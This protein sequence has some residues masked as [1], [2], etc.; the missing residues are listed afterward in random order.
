MP[1]PL[2]SR[3]RHSDGQRVGRA[4]VRLR[5]GDGMIAAARI[6]EQMRA[7]GKDMA[8]G[9]AGTDTEG[10]AEDKVSGRRQPSQQG[11]GNAAG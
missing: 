1:I 10:T 11:R 5:Q 8:T 4:G 2:T 9:H 7:Y 6:R 3:A